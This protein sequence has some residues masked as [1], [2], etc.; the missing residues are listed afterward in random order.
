MNTRR[1]AEGLR[2]KGGMGMWV[3]GALLVP[4][5]LTAQRPTFA[6]TV[7]WESGLINAPAAYIAPLSGDL[8]FS[9]IW[10]SNAKGREAASSRRLDGNYNL[11]VGASLLGRAEVGISIFT[12]DLKNGLFGKV[13]LWDQTDGIWRK[14]TLHWLPS[15]AVGVRNLGTN[16]SLDRYTNTNTGGQFNTAP[17][18]YGVATRS[19]VL[20]AGER[21]DRPKSQLSVTGGWGNGLFSDDGGFG[22]AYG[23]GTGGVFGGA[24][25]DFAAGRYSTVSLIAEHDAWTANF[26][27]RADLTGVRLAAMYVGGGKV[28]PATGIDLGSGGMTISIGWQTNVLALIRGNRLE[29]TT[30]RMNAE[31][32]SLDQQV[33]VSQQRIDV[34]EGQIDAARAIATSEKAAERAELERRL[35]DEQEALKRLQEMVKAKKP[36]A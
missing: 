36:P 13:M 16:K 26:G 35:K 27:V 21:A 10:M 3:A 5:I 20:S 25:L 33:K 6:P 28:N 30:Q 24:S 14:G 22:E 15:M 9:M 34:L 19:F 12:S 32:A 29:A 23:S 4:A 31:Q 2:P 17:T 18:F 8:S 11:S 1:K 7:F